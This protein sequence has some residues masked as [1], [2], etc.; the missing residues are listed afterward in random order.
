MSTLALSRT[1]D[2]GPILVSE[3]PPTLATRPSL[4]ARLRADLTASRNGRSFERAVR[5]AG[6]NEQ[7]DLLAA[8]RRA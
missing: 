6:H 5:S 8:R 2:L 7:G 3:L 4:F 1:P